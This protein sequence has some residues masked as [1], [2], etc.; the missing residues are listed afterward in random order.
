MF[1]VLCLLVSRLVSTGDLTFIAADGRE[2]SFGDGAGRPVCVKLNSP[3]LYLKLLI[4]PELYLG[5][6]YMEGLVTFE[7]GNIYELLR[8]LLCDALGRKPPAWIRVLQL[9]R[10]A[11]RSLRQFNPA[12]RARRNVAHHYDLS[13]ELYDLFLD[14]DR[15]YSCAYFEHKDVNLEEAQ[16]AKKRHIAAKLALEPGQTVLDIGSGWGGLGL[17]LASVEDIHLTGVTLSEQQL[18]YS[19][20]R[21]QK[22]G[23]KNNVEF[24]LQDYRSIDEKFDRIVSVGMFEHVGV[25]HY[26]RFFRQV[27]E[28]LHDDGIALVHSIG[29]SDGPAYTNPWIAKYIFPG[30]YIP[31]ISEVVPSIE[32]NGLWITDI[33]VLRNHYAETIRLWR[34]NFV[35]NWHKAQ[36]VY[37]ERFCRM[38][39]FYLATSETAFRYEGMMNFQVQM[40]KQQMTLPMTRDYMYDNEARLRRLDEPHG[41]SAKLHSKRR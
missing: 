32:R 31:A 12:G 16:H 4:N 13:D 29:R 26:S 10:F 28:L 35:R 25:G 8:I 11:T 33:E 19:R 7:K 15:Q 1:E 34:K 37:D 21:A 39:E 22:L 23:L 27:H 14:A 3:R 30:G 5:E 2:R 40:T 20:V 24:R 36:Q 41:P 38:W 18:E 9:W 17:Y 6:A